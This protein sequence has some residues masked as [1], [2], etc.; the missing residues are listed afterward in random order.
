MTKTEA[1]A[2]F[3]R[4]AALGVD[5]VSAEYSGSGDGGRGDSGQ[6]DGF[7]VYGPNR[8]HLDSSVLDKLVDEYAL[9]DKVTKRLNKKFQTFSAEL[10]QMTWDAID[11]SGNSGFYNS[12]GFGSLVFDVTARTIMLEHSNYTNE[13]EDSTYKLFDENPDVMNKDTSAI[14][15]AASSDAP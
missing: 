13:T 9:I 1:D 12:G 2:I 14:E 10:G 4:L 3:A 15:D 8:A 11:A 5:Y 7:A 6:L